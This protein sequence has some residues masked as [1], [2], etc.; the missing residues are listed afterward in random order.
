MYRVSNDAKQKVHYEKV[1]ESYQKLLA[2]YVY[3]KS[4]KISFLGNWQ[5]QPTTWQS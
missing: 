3:D 5:A 1:H 4:C 2:F